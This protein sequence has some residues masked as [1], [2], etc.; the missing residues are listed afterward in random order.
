MLL[1][2]SH[3]SRYWHRVIPLPEA[4]PH[5]IDQFVIERVRQP[6]G[7]ARIQ[8]LY[9]GDHSLPLAELGGLAGW[10]H[11]SP[12]GLGIHPDHGL[13]YAYRAV[14]LVNDADVT[15]ALPGAAAHPCLSCD[16]QPCIAACPSGAVKPDGFDVTACVNYRL[17]EN[18]SCKDQCLARL[19][20]P[21]GKAS[22][23]DQDQI[24]YHYRYS[25]SAIRRFKGLA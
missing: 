22:R 10:H 20:C 15:A 13:W 18:S 4:E 14:V 8:I 2:G 11:K 23:Y 5:P 9:P 3:G 24:T 19:S 25:L 7:Q 6:F 16:E 1:L 21:V 12:L 17:E